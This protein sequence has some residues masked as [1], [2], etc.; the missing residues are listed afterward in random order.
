MFLR[1]AEH[2]G[3][4]FCPSAAATTQSPSWASLEQTLENEVASLRAL[5]G[6]RPIW[7]CALC[8]RLRSLCQS[9]GLLPLLG[10]KGLEHPQLQ[11]PPNF[12]RGAHLTPAAM[13]LLLGSISRSRM[14]HKDVRDGYVW[15]YYFDEPQIALL[16]LISHPA[17]GAG[18][19]RQ[20]E[21]AQNS[22][23]VA[24]AVLSSFEFQPEPPGQHG[25]YVVLLLIWQSPRPSADIAYSSEIHEDLA[26]TESLVPLGPDLAHAADM[27]R[28]RTVMSPRA[29]SWP[30]DQLLHV[31]LCKDS[32][33]A[34]PTNRQHPQSPSPIKAFL[35]GHG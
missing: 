7:S 27:A 8:D 35:R 22:I 30:L 31:V 2:A 12:W 3:L 34:S 32:P 26:L 14:A 4:V 20:T 24:T 21:V 17:F 19:G 13:D 10:R 1:Q 28:R 16:H 33:M 18:V 11:Q 29:A 15:V 9:Q 6:G 5:L 23:R 25:R